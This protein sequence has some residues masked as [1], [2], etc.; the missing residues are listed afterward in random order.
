[1]LLVF[2][3]A[4]RILDRVTLTVDS[5]ATE[6]GP[7]ELST[8]PIP[9][10][11][12]NKYRFTVRPR[13]P[14][15]TLPSH[16]RGRVEAYC[17]GEVQ[18][19]RFAEVPMPVILTPPAP[20]SSHLSAETSSDLQKSLRSQNKVTSRQAPTPRSLETGLA[21]VETAGSLSKKSWRA[22]PGTEAGRLSQFQPELSCRYCGCLCTR[23]CDWYGR[24]YRIQDPV[25]DSH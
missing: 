13:A 10:E 9:C 4:R 25:L 24:R 15:P 18:A 1:M 21:R 14:D 17:T 12:I 5:R 23:V 22:N 3:C 20:T 16:Q 2:A 11:S 19:Q 7:V 8:E 6:S